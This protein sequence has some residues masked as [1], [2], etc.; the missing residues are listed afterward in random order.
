MQTT[1][2][3]LPTP[4]PPATLLTVMVLGGG[5][6]GG[7]PRTA[8][9]PGLGE[10]NPP[11]GGGNGASG[12]PVVAQSSGGYGPGTGLGQGMQLYVVPPSVK[13]LHSH[14]G[15]YPAYLL[16]NST[17]LLTPHMFL[18]Y[19]VIEVGTPLQKP[20]CLSKKLTTPLPHMFLHYS[21]FLIIYPSVYH[22]SHY[23]HPTISYAIRQTTH[24]R[25]QLRWSQRDPVCG[26]RKQCTQRLYQPDSTGMSSHTVKYRPQLN[27]PHSTYPT[28]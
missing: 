16:T 26:S 27:Y 22:I 25:I 21:S 13:K 24:Q 2:T 9:T 4:P 17:I 20:A 19:I 3:L 28:S 1:I 6:G 23:H 11:S 15:H 12:G 7:F 10:E 18:H 14:R 5:L 8:S